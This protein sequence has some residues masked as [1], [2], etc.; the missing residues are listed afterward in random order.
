MTRLKVIFAFLVIFC[1]FIWG[2]EFPNTIVV[3][4]TFQVNLINQYKISAVSI[5]PG[6]QSVKLNNRILSPSDYSFSYEKGILSLKEDIKPAL[7]D[8]IIITYR[9][10]KLSLK[11]KFQRRSLVFQYDEQFKDSIRIAKIQS[12]QLTSD[13]IF[14]ENIEK[15]GSIVRGFTVGTTKDFTLESGL[16]LQL[17]GQLSDDIQIV[18]ALTDENTPIQPEGNTETL[19]ELDK[20]FIEV[21]HPNAIGTFGDY[22][23]N[24]SIGEFGRVNRKLQGLKGELIFENHNFVGAVAGARGKFTSNQFNGEDGNQGPYRLFGENT[25]K[26]IVLIA[27]SERVYIDGEEMTRGENNDYTIEYS[28]AEITFTP[29]RLITS[30]S[31]ITVDFEYTDR[32]YQRNFFAA[33]SKSKFFDDRLSVKVGF[34]QESDDKNNPIDISIDDEDK[35]ILENAG[36]NRDKAIISGVRLAQPDSTGEING[37]YVKIDTLLNGEDYTYYVYDPGNDSALYNVSFSFVGLGNGDYTK[38]SLGNY[39]FVGKNQGSYLPVIYL[40]LPSKRQLAN[41][42][43]EGKPFENFNIKME[44]A[45]SNW[46]KNTFSSKDDGDNFGH[47]RNIQVSLDPSKVNIGEISLGKIGFSYKDRFVQDRFTSLDRI[48]EVEFNR[49]YNITDKQKVDEQLREF[50]LTLVPTENLNIYSQYGMLRRGENFSS[51]RILSRVDL[52]NDQS[53]NFKYN[54]DYVSSENRSASTNWLRQNGNL[55]Y[56]IGVVKP[57]FKFLHENREDYLN[58][59]SLLNSSLRYLEY[60]PYFEVSS[61][62][63]LSFLTEYSIREEFFPLNG[64]LTKQS[65]AATQNYQLTYN[66]IREVNSTLS[67]TL[68]DKKINEAFKKEGLGDNQTILIRSQSRFNLFDR[69]LNGDLY[70]EV[71]TQKSALQEKVF[72]RIEKGKGNYIYLGDLNNNGIKDENEFEPAAFD[73]E[74]ILVTIPSDELFP[75]IDL[76]TSTRWRADFSEIFDNDKSLVSKIMNPIST[77][78][79]WRIEENSKEEDTKKI[80]LMNF[81][82]FLNDSTTIRGSNLIQQDV[83]L[84]RNKN[85]FS[86]RF[87]FTERK[88]L[89]QFAG[90]TE[91][92]YYKEQGIRLRFQIADEISNQTEVKAIADNN[93]APVTSNRAREVS[94]S[95]LSSDFSYRIGRDLEFGFVFSVSQSTDTF[96][97]Q[98]TEVNQNSQTLRSNIN[99]SGRGRL[100]IELERDELVSNI[101]TNVIPF[102]ITKGRV[103]GK[104][105]FW[106]V[107]FD[108]RIAGNLQ[109]TL[110]YDGRLQSDSKV[111]HTMRAEARAYF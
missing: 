44:L 89:N 84:F 21:R 43:I 47:A 32:Q 78:T 72:V 58:N 56:K 30:A 2:Q 25:E 74:Y 55:F 31:R 26:D 95:E 52:T 22:D 35:K 29:N 11:K 87:R 50:G 91:R 54:F 57:G 69:F 97:D 102:E 34:F 92:G 41:I 108:Y 98:P 7:I 40:P 9:S 36:D 107:N 16:R 18:A 70:Y 75:V 73:G 106:R 85:D 68:R 81:S 20:V 6:T 86:I 12:T 61:W 38:Q 60:T 65:E 79:Y 13:V 4:D 93:D 45:G 46:D 49:H 64:V 53:V 83:Y 62:N 77:E 99:F 94:T 39:K 96:P 67:I 27:G 42:V 88:N 5:I 110:S 63:G 37:T 90:G 8:T 3:R 1:G 105:Y 51:D 103:I 111:V 101:S 17:A 33:N 80:Y 24:E 10:Y 71:S 82:S 48:D 109:T 19:D 59:D 66:G 23:Y 15:S 76:K 104:N 28:N 14:G 100:R